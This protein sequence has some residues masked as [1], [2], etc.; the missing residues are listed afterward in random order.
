MAK[1]TAPVRSAARER[2]ADAIERV[3][4]LTS[5]Y[6]ADVAAPQQRY[7]KLISAAI[8]ARREVDALLTEDATTMAAWLV[9]AD[10]SPRPDKPEPLALAEERANEAERDARAAR[11]GLAQ[12]ADAGRHAQELIARAV[13]YRDAAALAVAIE[14]AEILAGQ[15]L[16]RANATVATQAAI[17]AL[18]AAVLDLANAQSTTPETRSGAFN[19]ASKMSELHHQARSAAAAQRPIAAAR[20]FVGRL[21]GDADVTF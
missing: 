16:D 2:L 4:E 19:A 9:A 17:E 3:A 20:S 11:I 12:I 8:A 15:L 5:S 1:D 10:D 21:L 13:A 7:E 6:T 18:R 14:H